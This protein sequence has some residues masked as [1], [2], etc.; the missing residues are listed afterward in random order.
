MAKRNKTA[1]KL[2]IAVFWL[3]IWQAI[4]LLVHNSVLLVGPVETLSTLV[5]MLPKHSF[6]VS[7]LGTTLRVCAGFAAGSLIGIVMAGAAYKLPLV[8]ELLGP[9]IGLMKSIPVAS[10][11]I[12][13]II[14]FGSPMLSFFVTLIV[15]LPILYISTLEGL[16]STDKGLLEMAEVFH[17]GKTQRIRGI[18][19]PQLYPHFTSALSLASGMAFRS[20]IAA[21]VIGQPLGSLGNELYRAKI[22]L[23]TDRVLAVTLTSVFLAWALTRIIGLIL[24]LYD[25][26]HNNLSSSGGHRGN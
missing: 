10:F 2:I 26:R 21:E 13:L 11:V 3:V 14:W 8:R 6:Q 17:M 22:Y 20:G 18:Y 16:L 12:I 24:G 5:H 23:E 7:V 1:R 25:K 15:V 9:V 19:L 4:S